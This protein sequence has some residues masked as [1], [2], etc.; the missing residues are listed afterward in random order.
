MRARARVA[1]GH[2]GQ[3][4]SSN[5]RLFPCLPLRDSKKCRGWE[6][7]KK[8]RENE[9]KNTATPERLEKVVV[10][11]PEVG[12]IP[13]MWDSTNETEVRERGVY[14]IYNFLLGN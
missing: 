12:W 3:T 13:E 6:G 7:E 2:L 11:F 9:K 1:S 4:G 5:V 10:P 8:R 14:V